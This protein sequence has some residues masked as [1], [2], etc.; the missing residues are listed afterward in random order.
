[1]AVNQFFSAGRGVGERSEQDLVQDIV[2][3]LVSIHG[4][5]LIY[6]PRDVVKLDSLYGEDVLSAFTERHVI[7]MYIDKPLGYEGSGDLFTKFGI[8][9]TDQMTFVVSRRRFFE[10]T[11]RE[12][13]NEGD[14]IYFPIGKAL[15]EIK[16]VE[17]E[18]PFYSLSERSVFQLKCSLFV[19]SS[20]TIDTGEEELDAVMGDF[21]N[22]GTAESTND[23]F[24]D[25]ET[26]ESEGDDA[27]DFSENSPF[28]QW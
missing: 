12:F 7:E 4:H 10:V 17:D 26:I 14:L 15:F 13:P 22:G 24:D 23:V 21:L 2:D 16:F 1:M 3:E 11:G 6:A 28:G 8:D 18:Q 27:T 9:I 20:E 5:D 25:T 19:Y